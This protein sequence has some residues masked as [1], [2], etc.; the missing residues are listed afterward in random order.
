MTDDLHIEV[1]SGASAEWDRFVAAAEGATFCHLGGWQE[2][3]TSVFRHECLYLV[4]KD[5]RG[6]WRGVL[7]LVRVRSVLGHYLISMPFVNDGGPLGDDAARLRLVEYALLEAQHSGADLL[8]LRSR[9]EL[10]GPLVPSNRKITV[11]LA[12]PDSIEALWE[13]TFRA[14]LRSQARRPIKEGMTTRCGLSELS[15]F[16][17]VFACNMRDLGTPVL[18]RNFFER[19]A[20]TFGEQVIFTSVYTAAGEPAA[21]ACSVLWRDEVEIVW[22]SALREFN[23]FSPNMLLYARTMEESITRG[24]RLFNFGRCTP[25]GPT[26]KFKLQWGGY[27]VPLPWPSWSRVPDAGT[28]SP[29]RPVFQ[30]ATSVW[31]RLPMPIANRVGPLLARHLP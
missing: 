19:L 21:A 2:I 4:A 1:A 22:A 14:K 27:D 5:A 30:L 17:D 20:S 6:E 7:P 13:K 26:H 10:A 15:T 8:E 9:N 18:P 29:D 11:H 24:A 16:Y 3:M 28:P 31:R 12:L 23:K 25:G